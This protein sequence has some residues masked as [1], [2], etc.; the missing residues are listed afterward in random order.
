LGIPE[1]KIKLSRNGLPGRLLPDLSKTKS[2]KIRF[3]FIGTIIP[4]KGLHVLIEAFNGIK[5]E[6][7]ELKIYG[8][9]YAYAG[10]ESYL[11]SLRKNIE[12]RNIK[13]MAEFNNADV[14]DVFREIDVLIVPSIWNENAPLVIQ[15]AFSARTVV[16]ASNIGGIPELVN[17]GINGLLFRAGDAQ[18]LREKIECLAQDQELFRRLQF[19]IKQ[20]KSMADHA[21]ELEEV[22]SNLAG[23]Q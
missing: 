19:N 11:P 15:E 22:Y 18:D 6:N 7:A 17:D 10:F 3:A 21:G 14:A 23:S 12:N 5:N 16:I 13:F 4:A 2:E 8:K 20:A 1:H 9:L